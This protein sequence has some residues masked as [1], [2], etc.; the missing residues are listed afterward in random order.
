M[1]E[2]IKLTIAMIV[3]NEEKNLPRCLEALKPLMDQVKSE[4][5]ITD[6]GSTDRTVDIAKQYTDK[7]LFFEWCNDFAAARNTALEI[8]RGEWL[9]FLDADEVIDDAKPMIRFLLGKKSEQY[10]SVMLEFRNYKD[11][12]MDIS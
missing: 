8:A 2:T 6:T 1:S 12:G 5:I 4:L 7:V 10:N 11:E 3:K 9:L